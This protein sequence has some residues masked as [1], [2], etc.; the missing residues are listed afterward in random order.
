MPAALGCKTLHRFSQRKAARSLQETA[1]KVQ[2]ECA[3][4]LAL[5]LDLAPR[6][7]L[8]CA[9]RSAELVVKQTLDR[10]G[11]IDALINVAV[12]VPQTDLFAMTDAGSNDGLSVFGLRATTTT[13]VKSRA[14]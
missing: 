4:P 7:L 2:V 10:Y 3:E 11:R 12:A 14:T 6:A 5:A 9:S 1:S 8:S 13:A